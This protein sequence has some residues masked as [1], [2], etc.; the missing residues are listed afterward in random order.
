M[1]LLYILNSEGKYWRITSKQVTEISS[2]DAV[3]GPKIVIT[4]FGGAYLGV[5]TLNTAKTYAPAIIEKR[6]RDNGDV[7]G[8]SQIISLDFEKQSVANKLFFAAV[9]VDLYA[10][11]WDLAKSQQDHCLVVPIWRAVMRYAQKNICCDVVVLQFGLVLEAFI[12]K[13]SS[14]ARV[15]CVNASGKEATDWE[16]SL[17]YLAT[18]FRQWNADEQVTLK[19]VAWFSWPGSLEVANQA[20]L[21]SQYYDDVEFY[22]PVSANVL[23]ED[24]VVSSNINGLLAYVS[25]LDSLDKHPAK[26]LYGLES[27]LVWVSGAVI[28]ASLALLVVGFNWQQTAKNKHEE[29]QTYLTES[30]YQQ[31]LSTY[32][33]QLDKTL[34]DIDNEKQA[35][36]SK[37]STAV[38]TKSIPEILLDV[39]AVL[40]PKLQVQSVKWM[41]SDQSKSDS[42]TGL[43]VQ[44]QIEDGLYSATSSVEDMVS[45]LIAR[46]YKVK[47]LGFSSKT[48]A[49]IFEILVIPPS[50]AGGIK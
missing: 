2:L 5:E 21:F 38:K 45:K 4:D 37:M 23:L 11:Y 13:G 12:L 3:K 24:K 36:L 14:V 39:K 29:M 27:A 20:M 32:Q 26:W 8:A 50:L 35:L 30:S 31:L 22:E 28:A 41:E 16:R 46:G 43:F 19:Q 1:S 17:Q 6:L 10:S 47:D 25:P 18:E 48:N 15:L 40:D 42:E 34:V 33:Q 9:P 49:N 44:G 7:E